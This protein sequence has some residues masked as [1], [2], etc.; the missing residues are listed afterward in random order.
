MR[1]S[2]KIIVLSTCALSLT[3]CFKH[4]MTL[5]SG[6]G[7]ATKFN[8][9][10]QV[11]NPAPSYEGPAVSPG[12]KAAIAMERHDTDKVEKPTRLRTTTVGG[13][14]SGGDGGGR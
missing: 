5:G 7:D 9:A 8:M 14:S 11:V 3:G 6:H 4:H 10:A 2:Y 1:T 12:S 13:S